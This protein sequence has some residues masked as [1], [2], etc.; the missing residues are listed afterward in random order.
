[1]IDVNEQETIFIIERTSTAVKVYTS[2][3][4]VMRKLDKYY[5]RVKED[6]QKN[7]QIIAAEYRLDRN[8]LDRCLEL[9]KVNG[10]HFIQKQDRSIQI[11]QDVLF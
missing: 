4:T 11:M 8:I 5:P 7:G 1:M 2:D 9:L 10:Q 6:R 3:T